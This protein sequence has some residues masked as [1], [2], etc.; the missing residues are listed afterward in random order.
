MGSWD[1]AVRAA[2]C[3]ILACMSLKSLRLCGKNATINNHSLRIS[4]ER[5][6][7]ALMGFELSAAER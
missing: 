5:A 3:V 6:L 1:F 7:P 2:E 4:Y